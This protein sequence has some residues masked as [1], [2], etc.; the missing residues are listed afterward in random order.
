MVR[1][2]APAPPAVPGAAGG[3]HQGPA[4]A[5]SWG[6][7]L[8]TAHEAQ[9]LNDQRYRRWGGI[10][11]VTCIIVCPQVVRGVYLGTHMPL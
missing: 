10:S 7:F 9:L 4:P 6:G 5:R 8:G 2:S 3:F 1:A 11:S